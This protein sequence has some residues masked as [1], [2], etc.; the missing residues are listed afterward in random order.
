MADF[1]CPTHRTHWKR[2][3]SGSVVALVNIDDLE[4]HRLDNYRF[5]QTLYCNVTLV[6][7][8]DVYDLSDGAIRNSQWCVHRLAVTMIC[9]P[10]ASWR[11]SSRLVCS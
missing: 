7:I 1:E 11:L 6:L 9:M 10:I 5:R 8:N 2:L 3:R 4:L